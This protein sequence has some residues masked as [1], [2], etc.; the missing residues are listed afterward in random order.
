MRQAAAIIASA[1]LGLLYC[2]AL[3]ALANVFRIPERIPLF[4]D[5]DSNFRTGFLLAFVLPW[6]MALGAWIGRSSLLS[7]FL[8]RWAGAAAASTVALIVSVLLSPQLQSLTSSKAA[9]AAAVLVLMSLP[10]AST[11]GAW[12]ASRWITSR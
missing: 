8:R 9:N 6:C 1:L 4:S 7:L 10:L 2:V 12:L 3:V 11:V 5:D